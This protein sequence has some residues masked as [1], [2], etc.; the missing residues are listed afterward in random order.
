MP[1]EEAN[2]E[3]SLAKYLWWRLGRYAGMEEH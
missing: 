2:H 3:L 1:P